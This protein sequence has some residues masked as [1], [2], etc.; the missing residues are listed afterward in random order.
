MKYGIS[1][2]FKEETLEA[3]AKW[4]QQKP[5]EER[6]IEALESIDII[7]T[8]QAAGRPHDKDDIKILKQVKLKKKPT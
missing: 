7:A 6:L 1:H 8:K 5:I 2:S 4:F 3:K